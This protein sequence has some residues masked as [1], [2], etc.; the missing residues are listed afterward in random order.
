MT[1]WLVV[2][3]VLVAIPAR[4]QSTRYPPPPH[5]PDREAETHSHVWDEALDPSRTP[6]EQLVHDARML[7]K[8]N[9]VPEAEEAIGKLGRAI[10]LAPKRPEAYA[11]RG[12]LE[13]ALRRWT[14][15]ADDLAAADAHAPADDTG[16]QA[17]QWLAEGICQARAGRFADAE[18]TLARAASTPGASG[19]VWLRLGEVRIALGKLDEAIGAL[20]AAGELGDATPALAR[21]LLASAY[22]RARLPGE[23]ERAM[24]QAMLYD[25]TFSSIE[26]PTYPLLGAGEH[27]FLMGLAYRYG[28]PRAE[29]AQLYFRRFLALAGDSPWRKRAEEHLRDLATIELPH[30][31]QR[32]SGTASVDIDAARAALAR[33][34]PAMRACLAKVPATALE[35]SVTRVGP[36]TPDSVRDRPRYTVPAPGVTVHEQLELDTAPRE[37]IAGAERCLAPIVSHV[38]LPPIHD[39]DTWYVLSFLVI[40]P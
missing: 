5:D 19:E 18:Q 40:G 30:Q 12:E 11:L 15:C 27:E 14:P 38:A 29:Y 39:R 3:L 31:V 37:A 17:A 13:L 32:A 20:T 2:A 23:A 8:F 35:V 16:G 21:Y 7:A 25:P 4:A 28:I 34:M 1:R 36:R 24:K 22:D 26:T 33:A 6:Y 10:A 9:A